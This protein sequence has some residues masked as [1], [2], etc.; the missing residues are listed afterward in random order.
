MTI[1]DA[2]IETAVRD[3][4]L[5]RLWRGEIP[6]ATAYWGWGVAGNFVGIVVLTLAEAIAP[7][8]LLAL[9]IV[10]HLAFSVVICV[11]IWRSAGRYD[12]PHVWASLARFAIVFGP[13]LE[14]ARAIVGTS[15]P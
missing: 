3:G 15:A 14:I 8:V 4:I 10:L 6:L 12:G 9:L 2:D 13:L 5:G 1:E 7:A 11:A